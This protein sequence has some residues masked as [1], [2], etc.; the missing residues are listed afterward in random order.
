MQK[1]KRLTQSINQKFTLWCV[2]VCV[3]ISFNYVFSPM[4]VCFCVYLNVYSQ[5]L[6]RSKKI[7]LLRC[8][9]VSKPL[10]KKLWQ[11]NCTLGNLFLLFITCILWLSVSTN[12][13]LLTLTCA[14][15]FWSLNFI[16]FY[17][18][19]TRHIKTLQNAYFKLT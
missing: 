18:N 19:L 17:W 11:A 2:C 6:L 16:L 8:K 14:P 1:R 12:K 4:W 10:L 13:L 3:S 9:C 7:I 15:K 5:G